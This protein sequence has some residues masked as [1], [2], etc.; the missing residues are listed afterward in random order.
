MTT[1]GKLGL[2]AAAAGV[3]VGV[4]AVGNHF[5]DQQPQMLRIGPEPVQASVHIAGAVG[6]P[7]LYTLD[8][9]TRVGQAIEQAG[10]ATQ[11]A[12]L[13]ALN[14]AAKVVDGSRLYVPKIG[15]AVPT[16]QV[17]RV[18]SQGQ[19]LIPLNQATQTELEKIPGIGPVTARAIIDYRSRAG[20]FRSLQELQQVKGI[21]PKKLEQI[22]PYVRL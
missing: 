4:S 10:G 18:E 7:G 2:G 8:P 20:G 11:D 14:L 9:E 5:L 12:N 15:E 22:R 3:I 1:W 19:G 17:S 6:S 21:G 13:D 16:D